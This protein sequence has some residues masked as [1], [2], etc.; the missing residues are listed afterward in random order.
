MQNVRNFSTMKR[1]KV[2]KLS[3]LCYFFPPYLFFVP[4]MGFMVNLY[5]RLHRAELRS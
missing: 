4:F 5:S 3:K 1:M 2:V